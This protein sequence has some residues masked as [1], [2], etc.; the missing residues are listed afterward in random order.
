MNIKKVIYKKKKILIYGL[1]V[2][3]LSCLNNL[4]KNNLI[5]YFDDN[6]KKNK[7]KKFKKFFISKKKFIELNLII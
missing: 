2:S 3:G 5:K 4:K 1:G 6:I 7:Y